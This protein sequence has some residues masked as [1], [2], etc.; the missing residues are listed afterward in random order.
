M[1]ISFSDGGYLEFQR[2]NK[3]GKVFVIVAVKN[4]NNPLQLVVNSAEVEL[5]SVIQC[6]ESVSG[7]IILNK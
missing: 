1:K 2:S 4:A 6:V 7:P 3:Q 5:S